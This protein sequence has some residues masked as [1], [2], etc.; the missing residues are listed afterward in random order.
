MADFQNYGGS[1][2]ENAE[3]RKLNAEVDADSDSFEAWEKLVR[4]CESLEGGLNR[5]SSPQAL[6]TL[7]DA[8]DRFLL[9]FPLLF[10]YWKKYADLEFNISGPESAEMVY[11]RGCASITNSV[12]LW[13]DYCSFKMDT[14]H[15]APLVRELF[16]RAATFVGLDFLAHPFW[17]KYIEYE[18]RQE[19]HDKIYAILKRVIHI[20]MHQYARYYERFRTLSH[21]R[22]LEE[23]A[24]AELLTRFRAEVEAEAASFGAAKSEAEIER[25]I[26]AKTDALFYEVFQ[27]TQTET[28]KRWTYES[29]VKRPYFHVTELDHSQLANW[30][31]YLDFEEA[32]GDFTRI[33]ALYER[34]LVTCAF[35][36]E[37]WLRY[38]R[39]MSAQPNKDE[40]V[41][42]I[43]LRAVTLFVPVSRP[44]I[45]M[46]FAYSE[47]ASGRADIAR[48]LHEAILQ[49]LP[50][51]VEAIISWANLERRQSGLDAAI[52]IYKAQ[53]D[54]PRVDLYTKAALVT[55]WADLLWKVKGS[56]DEARTVFLNNVQWYADSR[57]F[58]SKWLD[59]EL[60]QPTNAEQ[61][62][63]HGE[64]IH[65]V[66]E[67]MRTKSRMS[68]STK[69]ALCIK[70]LEYLQQRGVKDAMKKFLEIDREM[71][72]PVSVSKDKFSA[73]DNGVVVGELDEAIRVNAEAQY[74]SFYSLYG[75]PDPKATG[76][77][78]FN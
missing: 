50:N 71:A 43:F 13:T 52:D 10:G 20:P 1:D 56:V 18:E 36:D 9:K 72:G 67:E 62:A 19:A 3:L 31:K 40:E 45:R 44:G 27:Q 59:F 34:C 61:E 14:T 68:T 77:A 47:E 53:I 6:A 60:E 4:A 16:E 54:S 64:R 37:F 75:E 5:N 21:S 70:Y 55:Q 8:Y 65:N 38:T 63:E 49:K 35:Y 2:E 23:I 74:F 69:K 29:E 76:P 32:E 24:E 39:W 30:R 7:R 25:D 51:C 15:V 22:P 33:T 58:W 48:A 28:T 17:D 12:D 41:R 73:K 78:D 26:R 57:E 11:E 42:N 66:V 46:Q